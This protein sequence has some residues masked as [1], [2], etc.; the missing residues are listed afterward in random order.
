M[1][2][3]AKKEIIAAFQNTMVLKVKNDQKLKFRGSCL[4]EYF[5]GPSTDADSPD[6]RVSN[7]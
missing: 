6:V 3:K 2:S 5:V 1:H 4:I 7:G